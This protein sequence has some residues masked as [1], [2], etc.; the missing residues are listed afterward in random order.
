MSYWKVAGVVAFAVAVAGAI[1][2]KLE[3]MRMNSA[4]KKKTENATPEVKSRGSFVV[5]GRPDSGKTTFI[6]RL[7][8]KQPPEKKESTDSIKTYKKVPLNFLNGG[9][10]EVDEIADMPGNLDFRDKWLQM[11]I[12]KD[13]VFYL[14]DLSS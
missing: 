9:L 2:A 8:G 6:S 14:I 10:F 4:F 13:H 3:V 11:V 5:W 1:G 7:L 12:E